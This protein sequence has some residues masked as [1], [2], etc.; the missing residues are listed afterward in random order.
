LFVDLP[1]HLLREFQSAVREPDDFHT[2]WTDALAEA[3]TR[4]L[5]TTLTEAVLRSPLPTI[6]IQELSFTGAEGTR[7]A[8]WLR[9]PRHATGPLPVVVQF[10]GYGDGRGHAL[11][12]LTW[13][14]AGF[15]HLVVD[16]R[17]QQ[18]GTTP[19]PHGS[20]PSAD[21]FLTRGIE[22]PR[23]YFYR[24]VYVDAV[25]AVEAARS[26]DGL[27]ASRTVAYGASQ[28]GG[29]A[30]AMTALTPLAG[31]APVS[32]LIAQAPF[33]CDIWRASTITDQQPYAELAHFLAARRDLAAQAER[34]LAYIDGVVLARRATPP[35]LFSAGLMDGITP[36]STVFAAHNAYTGPKELA[37]WPHNGHEAGGYP[38]LEAAIEFARLH[39]QTP[40]TSPAITH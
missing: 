39:T 27:D 24:R 21:S 14:A 29:I 26:L 6:D 33:L 28:G 3:A 5:D 18:N 15:A 10:M 2:F 9:R 22:S 13:A 31:G 30:L 35:S 19:D 40:S 32:A 4:P 12:E 25:R 38:D 7:I 17:G 34:T 20:G 37:V 16:V 23:D 8:A 11:R 36:P 1:E